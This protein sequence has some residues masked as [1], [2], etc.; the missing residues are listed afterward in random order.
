MLFWLLFLSINE[1]CEIKEWAT[2]KKANT[3]TSWEGKGNIFRPPVYATEGPVP[4]QA[5]WI[6]KHYSRGRDQVD[7]L[8]W[9]APNI[10]RAV[11]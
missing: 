9:I 4:S 5:L 3:L 10:I 11:E 8:L 7:C 1:G 6:R 2:K